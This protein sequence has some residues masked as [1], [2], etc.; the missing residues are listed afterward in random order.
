MRIKLN[1]C[2]QNR[3]KWMDYFK[4]DIG[5]KNN[6][7]IICFRLEEILEYFAESDLWFLMI[8]SYGKKRL[9]I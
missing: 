5:F 6:G 7:L 9:K 1:I 4:M 2:N 3:I 8:K